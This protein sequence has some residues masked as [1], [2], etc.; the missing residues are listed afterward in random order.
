MG[1]HTVFHLPRSER[2]TH[3]TIRFG[4]GCDRPEI[5][6]RP[7]GGKREPVP[8]APLPDRFIGVSNVASVTTASGHTPFGGTAATVP[9]T[10]QAENFDEGASGGI[11]T[12]AGNTGGKYRTTDVDLESTTDVGAGYNVGRTRP[13]EWLKYLRSRWRAPARTRSTC[14]SP[15][16]ARGP[17]CISDIDGIDRTGPVNVPNTGGWGGWQTVRKT[18]PAEYGRVA[19]VADRTR[20][21]LSLFSGRPRPQASWSDGNFGER[22]RGELQLVP[23]FEGDQ[24][25]PL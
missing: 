12:T 16:S 14:E 1:L 8:Y 7:R 10:I 3:G 2:L 6:E 5:E 23:A 25:S 4:V 18:E 22:R 9:G 17:G 21:G 13:E 20:T 11:D 24:A 15:T 19:D